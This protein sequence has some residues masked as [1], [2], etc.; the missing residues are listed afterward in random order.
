MADFFDNFSVFFSGD[1]VYVSGKS[2]PLGQLSTDILNLDSSVLTEIDRRVN[3]FVPTVSVMLQE[4]AD[5]AAAL[6]QEK[7]NAVWDVVCELPLYRDLW[8][9]KELMYELLPTMFS[10]REKWEV[11]QDTTSD[12]H[13]M[14]EKFMN[15]LECF[16]E[17][18][19]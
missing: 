11:V 6:A 4:K 9:D 5:S 1:H 15:G 12:E 3:A 13:I 17:L 19:H 7:L 16:A 2:F 18:S 14:F 10:D 8:M